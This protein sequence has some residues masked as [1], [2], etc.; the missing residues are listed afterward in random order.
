MLK[1]DDVVGA[2]VAVE[3]HRRPPRR[4]RARLRR[5][6]SLLHVATAKFHTK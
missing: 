6:E 5:Q 4:P 2:V 1:L 3:R